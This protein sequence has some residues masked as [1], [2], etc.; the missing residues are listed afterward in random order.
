MQA[1]AQENRV[2]VCVAKCGCDPPARCA[3]APQ[4][5]RQHARLEVVAGHLQL[6]DLGAVN[7]T[8]VNDQKLEGGSTR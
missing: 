8:Y 3:S 7:G 6:V 5:S 1:Q 4:V 2:F